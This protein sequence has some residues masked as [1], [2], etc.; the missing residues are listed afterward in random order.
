MTIFADPQTN[1][2]YKLVRKPYEPIRST[3]VAERYV[4]REAPV[5]SSREESLRLAFRRLTDEW[6]RNRGFTSSAT[7]MAMQPAY[8]RIIGMGPAAAP[9]ILRELEQEPD[10]WF[11]ALKAITGADPARPEDRGDIIAM[12]R[13]WLD[14]GRR[15]GLL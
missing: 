8:Q 10:H 12:Q 13:A 5:G 11:W 4:L 15:R 9:L 3:V 2:L 7:E 14:W 1:E 6:R